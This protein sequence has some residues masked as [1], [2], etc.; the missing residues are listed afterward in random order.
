MTPTII[1][2]SGVTGAGKTTLVNSLAQDLKA[3]ALYWVDFDDISISPPDYVD[4]Y[5]RG[6]DFNE[7]DYSSLAEAL[8]TLG[9]NR[10]VIH[11]A[12]NKELQPTKYI[13]FDA[14]LGRL[15]QQTGKYIDICIHLEVPLD[16]SLCR[17]LIRD[18]TNQDKTKDEL[19]D[20]LKFYLSESR[21]LFFDDKLKAKADFIING[22]LDTKD[23]LI[24]IRKILNR[25]KS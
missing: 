7:W 18:F 2:I 1:G 10:S 25:D 14:P 9:T 5:H 19:I 6:Q 21:P 22:M 17:R 24:K 13:L 8:K 15:H 4:W 11:P 3:S 20:E 12:L 16:I 23:Q